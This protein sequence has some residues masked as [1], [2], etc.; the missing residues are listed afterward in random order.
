V[1]TDKVLTVTTS[2]HNATRSS[3]IL[4]QS[5]AM[6]SF[7]FLYTF[8]RH[9]I[10]THQITLPLGVYEMV[11]MREGSYCFQRIS[12]I[13]ILSVC[14]SIRL[15]HEWISRKRRKLELQNFHCRLP[16]RL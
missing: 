7:L 12:A 9:T 14:L 3:N 6:F 8:S 1:L 4:M 5:S 11:S 2:C 10:P 13:A 15:S 16:R